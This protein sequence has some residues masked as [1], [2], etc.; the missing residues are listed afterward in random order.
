MKGFCD[1]RSR[2]VVRELVVLRAGKIAGIDLL[3]AFPQ[4][5]SVEAVLNIVHLLLG[6]T[7]TYSRL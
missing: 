5:P 1:I 3:V 7:I 4:G 6:N 2:G